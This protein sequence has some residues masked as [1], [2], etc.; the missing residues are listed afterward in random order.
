MLI[1]TSR[2][3]SRD[4]QKRRQASSSKI[5][6]GLGLAH[7]YS[8]REWKVVNA[9]RDPSTI[10]TLEGVCVI[11]IDAAEVEDA[12]NA[13]GIHFEDESLTTFTLDPGHINTRLGQKA[14]EFMGYPPPHSVEDTAPKIVRFIEDASRAETSGGLWRVDGK[15]SQW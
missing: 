9:V 5:A 15:R 3:R 7:E 2:F 12:K 1:P 13:R 10:P 4:L 6:L 8:R 14:S 11:K